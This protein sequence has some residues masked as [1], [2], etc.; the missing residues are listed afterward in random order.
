MAPPLPDILKKFSFPSPH[1]ASFGDSIRNFDNQEVIMAASQH[2]GKRPGAGRPKKVRTPAATSAGGQI[3]DTAEE[4]LTAVVAGTVAPD[5]V[6]VQAAKTLIAY[7]L[8]R[9]RAPKK[10]PTP[11]ELARKEA[12]AIEDAVAAEFEAKAAAIRARHTGGR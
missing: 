3:F 5:A 11:T 8:T 9:Q 6:R 10:A 2:G 7:Q 4:Y 12:T 1:C